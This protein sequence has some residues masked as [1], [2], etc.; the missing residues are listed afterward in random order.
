MKKLAFIILVAS[1]ALS[2][3]DSW[4]AEK[5][6][7]T[8]AVLMPI[9]AKFSKHD[10]SRLADGV[11][12]GMASRYQLL[13]GDEVDSV[14]KQVFDE[15]NKGLN[16][17]LEKCHRKIAQHFGVEEIISLIIT[18]KGNATQDVTLTGVNVVQ[19]KVVFQK[20][21]TAK[22]ANFDDVLKTT[23]SLVGE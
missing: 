5:N 1:F 4:S 22:S 17:D 13:S 8:K 3:S 11:V 6:K 2:S 21:G 9:T 14:V 23:V 7:P 20:R 12:K 16:C 18:P 10:V 15:E 19:N